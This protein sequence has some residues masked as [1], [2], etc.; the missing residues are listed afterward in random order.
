MKSMENQIDFEVAARRRDVC[1]RD[2]HMLAGI[3]EE[4]LSMI[5]AASACAI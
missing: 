4:T 3:D 1:D 5:G 2:S